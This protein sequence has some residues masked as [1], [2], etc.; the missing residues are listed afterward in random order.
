MYIEPMMAQNPSSDPSSAATA[1]FAGGCF[2]CMEPPFKMLD[3]VL[4]VVSGYTGGHVANPTYNQVCDG[5]TGHAEAVQV[6][7]DP[8]RISYDQL[9]DVFW[10]N[11]DPTVVNRQF[12]DRGT[13]YRTG[14]FY[15]DE[16][17]KRAAE[18]SKARLAK[19]GKFDKPI[20]TEITQASTFYP[21]EDYHQEYYK[22][23][24]GHYKAYRKGSGR[25]DFLKNTWGG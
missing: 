18:E 23:N 9:L 6:T 20:V 17:Q 14:V 3:G 21:A 5:N 24:A 25:E 4:T 16:A 10:Q 1:T 13:Q 11:I 19:S 8:S 12:A 15:H 22:K 2:W 7:F